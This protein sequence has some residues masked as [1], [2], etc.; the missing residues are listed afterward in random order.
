MC[1]GAVGLR[2]PAAGAGSPSTSPTLNGVLTKIDAALR[3]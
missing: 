1:T 3:S 2:D